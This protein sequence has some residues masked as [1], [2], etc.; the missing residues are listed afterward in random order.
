MIVGVLP[1]G[2]AL[3]QGFPNKPVTIV[4]PFAAGSPTD[5]AARAFA[6]E[7]SEALSTPVVIDNRPGVAQ[8]IAGAAVARARADGYT[9]LFAN[10][11]AVVPPSIQSGLPY[12]GIR[13]FAPI[14]DI[15]TICYVLAASPNVPAN[16]L[17]EFI[18]L[19]KADPGKYSFGSSGLAS[20]TQLVAEMFNNRI[21]VKPIH[22]PYKGANQI[23]LDLISDRVTYGFLPTGAMEFVRTGKLK[24]FGLASD[25]RDVSY[26]ELPTMSEAGLPG[27]TVSIRFVLVAPKQTPADVAGKL[28]AAANK[29]ISNDTFYPKVKSIGGVQISKPATPAQVGTTIK[30]DEAH[31]ADVVKKAEI[32]LE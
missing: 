9:L 26:P 13:D 30:N 19:L 22:V 28:N 8:S 32:V 21:G 14:S 15:M 3:A 11:P 27:F 12:V 2:A 17:K 1:G 7:F 24:S 6:V 16:N 23:Q 20:P 10:L 4:V 5:A 25:T 18:A 31:W 29:V